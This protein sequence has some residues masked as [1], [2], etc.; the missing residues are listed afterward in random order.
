MQQR[1]IGE[2]SDDPV[3]AVRAARRSMH[4]H[5]PPATRSPGDFE[6]VSLPEAD[7]DVLRDV[8]VDERAHAVIEIGLAYGA[9]ALAVAEALARTAPDAGR[10]IVVDP[11]QDVFGD[12]GWEAM[13]DAGREAATELIR[14]PSQLVLPQLVADGA[15]F[16]AAFVDGS[17]I[18]HNVFVDLHF[19]RQ[20]VAPGGL[21]VLDDGGWPS[22]ATAVRYFERNTGWRRVDLDADTRLWAFR[23]PDPP[24]EPRFEDFVPFGD[25][26]V[27]GGV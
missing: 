26:P 18:F 23:L 2:L 25:G 13:V 16:D 1:A 14:A 19:L 21:V 5:G 3:A 17:H 12:A 8:L 22:V 24:V 15:T 11:Y 9:S 6:R 20:L 27:D 7:A 10:H 4:D